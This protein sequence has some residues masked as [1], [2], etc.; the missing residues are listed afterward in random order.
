MRQS[1]ETENGTIGSADIPGEND[2]ARWLPANGKG[3]RILVG[4]ALTVTVGLLV[5]WLADWT[6]LADSVMTLTQRPELLAVLLASYTAAFA[7][8][9]VAWR[10]L[11]TTRPGVF[12]LFNCLQAALLAN[13]LLPFKLGEA[14]RPLL[15]SRRGVPLSE[16]A[17]TTAV[18]RLLDFSCLI[19]IAAVCGALVNTLDGRMD[20]LRS[21]AIPIV[22]V[23]ATGAALMALRYR[24]LDR[25]APPL[26]RGSLDSL[27]TQLARISAGRVISAVAWTLPSWILEAGV[28][29]VAAQ[30]LGVE[31]SV[32]ALIGVTAFTI[33]FQVFHITPGGIGVYEASMTGALYALGIP[34][35]Q[36]LA[37]AVLTHGLKFAYSYTVAAAFT[38]VAVREAIPVKGL[39]ALRGSSEGDKHASRFEIFAARA[40][41]VLNEGKP[42]TPVFTLGILGLLSIPHLADGGLLAPGRAWPC[43]R[44]RRCSSSSIA[45]ISR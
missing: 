19:L 10:Q 15:A 39:G 31:L 36:G 35:E 42:F 26:L 38:L 22:V 12:G 34:W 45:S 6:E 30:A 28:L 33:L 17:A 27:R 7:L 9:A 24:T 20:W 13:H 8:R 43:W 16:A 18:A 40:W 14:A 2:Q 1:T 37:L 25:I 32:P 41:N 3:V 44:W 23:L 11:M 5:W 21:L 29:L 4:L